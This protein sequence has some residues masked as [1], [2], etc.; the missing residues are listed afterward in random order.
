MRSSGRSPT[1]GFGVLA[2]GAYVCGAVLSGHLSVFAR[3]P[4]LDGLSPPPPY[5]W[6]KPPPDLAG[7]NQRPL[8][9]KAT[10]TFA[11]G[12]SQA[13]V[14]RTND[15]QA[16][17]VLLLGAIPVRAGQ[18]S[19]DLTLDPLASATVGKPPGGLQITGNVYRIRALY[20]PSGA[21]VT[22][23]AKENQ[24]ILMYPAPVRSGERH[25]ILTSP[26]GRTWTRLRTIDAAFQHQASSERVNR[27][28]YFAVAV[29]GGAGTAASSSGGGSVVLPIVLAAAV[30]VLIAVGWLEY[31]RRRGR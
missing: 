17:V 24:V 21:P 1:L 23:L 11:N 13:G 10:I 8:S 14:F 16:L 28:G 9:G 20:E 2:L 4:L 18:T 6:V 12:R 22:T 26:G 31:R 3:R 30:I 7:S 29:P 25:V 5:R 15:S 27:L 19:A